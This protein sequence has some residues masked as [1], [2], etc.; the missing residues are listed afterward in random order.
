MYSPLNTHHKRG[1]GPQRAAAIKTP[2]DV[3][4]SLGAAV[5]A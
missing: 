1:D 3:P 2:P 5:R 4:G